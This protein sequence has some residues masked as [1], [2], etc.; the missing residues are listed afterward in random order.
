MKKILF[1]LALIIAS[2]LNCSEENKKNFVL[3]ISFTFKTGTPTLSTCITPVE[4]LRNKVPLSDPQTTNYSVQKNEKNV[5]TCTATVTLP[6]EYCH[7]LVRLAD[8]NGNLSAS[9]TLLH[10]GKT[11]WG[12]D[13]RRGWRP[14]PSKL[15][16]SIILKSE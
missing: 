10:T 14:F 12:S 4:K 7:I 15:K 8:Q 3:N 6:Q 11:N 13:D 5:I 2:F 9:A 1:Y 16:C